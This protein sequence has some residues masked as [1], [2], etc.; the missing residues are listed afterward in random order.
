METKC[1]SPEVYRREITWG[2]TFERIESVLLKWLERSGKRI[3]VKPYRV[4]GVPKNGMILTAF[5]PKG[6]VAEPEARIAEVI[7][8]DVIDSGRTVG[9]YIEQYPDKPFIALFD[10][11]IEDENTW[12]VFPWENEE[13]DK[14]DLIARQLEMIGEDPTREGLVKT[15]ERVVR[16]WSSLFGGY[17]KDPTEHCKAIFTEPGTDEMVILRDVEFYSTCEHHMLPF[18]GK[19]HVGYVPSG[20]RV[21]GVSKIARIIECF[22]RR[23][24]I[25]ERL[26]RQIADLLSKTLNPQ[27]VGVVLEAK[28]LCMMARGIEKQNSVMTTSAMYGLF[29]D[30]PAARAEFLD[31]IR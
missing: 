14:A 11:R 31:R 27:G 7:L 6:F 24:Q 17:S 25:Q 18:Y 26:T 22:S 16:S 12:L 5:L 19:A 3:G 10:K 2:E 30:T 8:D 29:R 4:Y 21:L 13:E 20:G 23:L 28:H 15:P 9:R 1:A